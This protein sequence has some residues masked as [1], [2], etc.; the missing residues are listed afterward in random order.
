MKLLEID[1]LT[2][3]FGGLSA[4]ANLDLAVSAGSIASVIGPNGAGKT[5]VFNAITGIYAPTS[6]E[7]RFEGQELRRPVRLYILLSCLAIGSLIGAAAMLLSADINELWRATI[8]RTK[9]NELASRG[10]L[11]TGPQSFSAVEAWHNFRE[12]L[13]GHLAVEYFGQWC[14][15]PW[16]GTHHL[17]TAVNRESG[18]QFAARL[19]QFVTGAKSPD[20]LTANDLHPADGRWQIEDDRESLAS[21]L[22]SLA[23]EHRSQRNIELTMLVLGLIVGAAG[24]FVVWNRSRRTPDVIAAGGIARTFQNIRLF[25]SM[26]VLENVQVAIDHG[27]GHGVR[28]MLSFAV[29][30]F[31]V[32]GGLAWSVWPAVALQIVVGVVGIGLLVAAQWHKRRDERESARRAFDELA[33]VG[34]QTKAGMLASALA[35]GEQR[36]LEIARALALHPRLLLLDEPVAGMNPTES[37]ELTGLIR[38]IRDRGI[39]VLLIEHH[40]NVVMGISDRIAVL[41]HGV[42]I[43]EGTPA[44]V[45]ANPAVIEAYLGKE[46]TH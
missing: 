11:Q 15:V 41:D 34:L 21:A 25:S 40:M 37:V 46:E 29:V 2:M 26:T 3:R 42:K 16:N 18:E 32:A 36:R 24:T 22:T 9:R 31:V 19:D 8:T 30:W 17:A 28:R 44:E 39:T 20:S 13:G 23:T 1:K 6:G 4:V 7:I 12:Y 43:A 27:L 35:Y 45:R 14:V 38:R 5:T 33:M 10:P